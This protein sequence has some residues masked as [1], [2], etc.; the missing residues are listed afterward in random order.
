M[1][2]ELRELIARALYPRPDE[3]ARGYDW[4]DAFALPLVND[5]KAKVL[6]AA[7]DDIDLTW[8]D[9]SRDVYSIQSK[10][11]VEAENFLE[12]LAASY[13]GGAG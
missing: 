6:R 13:E 3:R 8:P 11:T 12:A 4:Y 5:V 10:A 9:M 7:A 2:A 1:S